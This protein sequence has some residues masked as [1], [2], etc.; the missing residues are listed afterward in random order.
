[1]RQR[2]KD[3]QESV[4]LVAAGKIEQG[5]ERL[6]AANRIAVIP[7]AEE[8]LVQLV[9]DYMALSPEERDKTL[10]LAGTNSDRQLITNSIR[11]ELKTEGV[12]GRAAPL[13]QLKAKDLSQVQTRYSH[14]YAVGDVVVP[15]REYKRLGLTKFQPYTVEALEKNSLTLK[16]TDG[17]LCT[18]D[19]MAFRK[20]VYE[21]QQQSIE[22]A[23]GDRLKWKRNDHKIGHRN[24]QEFVVTAISANHAKVKYTN[25]KT[26][27]VDLNQL[28]HLDY[29]LVSTTY[30]SQGKTA[31]RVL[32]AADKTMGKESFYVAVSR[33]KYD[34]KIYTED[35]SDLLKL[36]RKSKA[37][38]IASEL[39]SS[40]PVAKQAAATEQSI[41]T[42]QLP[43]TNEEITYERTYEPA[44][45]TA[46]T[47]QFKPGDGN[48]IGR[49]VNK[50][51]NAHNR[52]AR[53]DRSVPAQLHESGL[54]RMGTTVHQLARTSRQLTPRKPG[55]PGRS[56]STNHPSRRPD[57]GNY[58]R[59][60]TNSKLGAEIRQ[61][62]PRLQQLSHRT[63]FWVEHLE[64][65]DRVNAGIEN[66]GTTTAE[67]GKYA[68]QADR[69]L[70]PELPLASQPETGHSQL[71]F[72]LQQI[73]HD[74]STGQK[75]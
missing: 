44:R 50:R 36:A 10:V 22:I 34:L 21:Q 26:D 38:E 6:D 43:T 33:A 72:E 4:D 62:D 57:W 75:L 37:K 41:S 31:N 51:L 60:S 28:Q 32:I 5:M 8:R 17:T 71:E 48:A 42:T 9:Q 47:E 69:Q 59:P 11:Q 61:P 20:T 29:A 63:D 53:P 7:G 67:T 2:V 19:P 40:K 13:T 39:I 18:L 16:A 49:S 45:P 73:S 12:L 15:T 58:K 30:S 55:V 68:R 25:G 52:K 3:L 14:H 54:Q 65:S 66:S 24:G 1:L 64:S 46:D 74:L 56:K 70:E 35:K 23:V 27:K